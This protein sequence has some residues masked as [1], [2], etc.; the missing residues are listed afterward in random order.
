M[1]E[2]N[3]RLLRP[4]GPLPAPRL[5]A[6]FTVQVETKLYGNY[7][8]QGRSLNP[9]GVF[10]ETADLLPLET[11]VTLRFVA[12]DGVE[13]VAQ[14]VVQNHYYIN[15]AAADG[16]RATVGMSVRFKSFKAGGSLSPGKQVPT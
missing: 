12:T 4:L 6:L 13:I 7:T 2:K 8:C 3:A 14:G 9:A 10:L 15:Y 5:D 16:P 11:E 1:G